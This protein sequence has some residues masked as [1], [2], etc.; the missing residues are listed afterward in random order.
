MNQ[1]KDNNAK[2][3]TQYVIK[4]YN[5]I[6]NGSNGKNFK[7]VSPIQTNDKKFTKNLL[8]PKKLLNLEEIKQKLIK[9]ENLKSNLTLDYSKTNLHMHAYLRYVLQIW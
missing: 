5:Q 4:D 8:K 6:S 9:Q 2:K 3:L 7:S 1:D